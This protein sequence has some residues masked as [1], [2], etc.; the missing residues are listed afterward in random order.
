MH[1]KRQD[2]SL[3]LKGDSRAVESQFMSEFQ[4]R[5]SNDIQT[6]KRQRLNKQYEQVPQSSQLEEE[7]QFRERDW[8]ELI[9]YQMP[10]KL[11]GI[12]MSVDIHFTLS[13]FYLYKI[14]NEFQSLFQ[15]I[16]AKDKNPNNN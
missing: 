4:L 14:K 6:I 16:Q 5:K 7:K 10:R 11:E 8:F 12:H 3:G 15:L 2:S 9:K 1:G 13:L